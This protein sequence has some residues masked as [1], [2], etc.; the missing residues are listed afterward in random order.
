MTTDA[1]PASDGPLIEALGALASPVRLALLRELRAPKTLREIDVRAP[2]GPDQPARPL[3][4]QTIKEHLD[5]LVQIGV[6]VAHEAQ[7]PYGATVEYA[8]NHQSLFAL[9][10]EFRELA[11]LRPVH[12]PVAPTVRKEAAPRPFSIQGPCLV[13]VKGLDEGRTFSLL[14]SKARAALWTVGRRRGAEV[15]LDFDPF[16]SSE[17]ASI[18]HEGQAYHVVDLP[19]SRNGTFLNFQPLDKGG[20]RV[21]SNGDLIG[22]GRSLLMFRA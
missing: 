21:L 4:R 18:V 9:A 20:R 7:R 5:R 19:E 11:R 3:A 10:E 15:P 1:P 6:V 14:P 13:L 2:A 12:E 22:V 17:H 16:V 8:I